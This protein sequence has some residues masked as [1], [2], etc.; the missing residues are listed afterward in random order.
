MD[1][2]CVQ[3]IICTPSI[4]LNVEDAYI[5]IDCEGWSP[6][7]DYILDTM[8]VFEIENIVLTFL[9]PLF[10]RRQ[11]GYRTVFSKV[12]HDPPNFFNTR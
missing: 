4:P 8:G 11:T 6:M 9:T 12:G 1:C 2:E 7:A 10:F 5:W 3:D